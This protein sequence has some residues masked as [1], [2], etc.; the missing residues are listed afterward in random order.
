MSRKET[1]EMI[2]SILNNIYMTCKYNNKLI[3]IKYILCKHMK[4]YMIKYNK[5]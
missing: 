2:F 5:N 1:I 3:T 4:K